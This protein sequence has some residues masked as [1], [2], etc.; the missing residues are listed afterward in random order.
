MKHYL[1]L[2]LILDSSPHINDKSIK[3]EMDTNVIIMNKNI[4]SKY[5][6]N[7]KEDILSLFI[8]LDPMLKDDE[9]I[10]DLENSTLKVQG[11]HSITPGGII[12]TLK[13]MKSL[14]NHFTFDYIVRATTSTFWVLPKLKNMLLNLPRNNIFKGSL[15]FGPFVSGSGM[16]FSKDVVDILIETMYQLINYSTEHN[17]ND[18]VLLG[19]FMPSIGI[20]LTDM[21]ICNFDEKLLTSDELDT[22]IKESDSDEICCY[23]VKTGCYVA[24]I[25][26]ENRLENDS[27]ILNKLYNYFYNK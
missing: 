4:W 15:Y 14:K 23:R 3:W 18:D 8:Q 7:E 11:Y 25:R 16:I 5:M 1:G 10:L 13:S 17:M 6:H 12:M 24:K 19:H 9:Y 22:I 26:Y 27:V 2:L 21:K 20:P